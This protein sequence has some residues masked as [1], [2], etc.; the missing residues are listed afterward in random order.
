MST[1]VIFI[2]AVKPATTM[3]AATVKVSAVPAATPAAAGA[4]LFRR[5]WLLFADIPS[6]IG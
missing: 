4:M 2:T 5:H 1:A 3:E 6:R